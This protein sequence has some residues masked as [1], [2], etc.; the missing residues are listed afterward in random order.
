ME[1]SGRLCAC[2]RSLFLVFVD[3]NEPVESGPTQDLTDFGTQAGEHQPDVF[4]FQSPLEQEQL[5]QHFA[6]EKLDVGTIHNQR[7]AIRAIG[8]GIPLIGQLSDPL[9]ASRPLVQEAHS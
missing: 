6:A 1:R 4:P 5:A 8:Y 3:L 2:S 9:G 7:L